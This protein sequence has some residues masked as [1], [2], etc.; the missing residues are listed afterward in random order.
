P[1][2]IF[3][4]L[5]YSLQRRIMICSWQI[6]QELSLLGHVFSLALYRCAGLPT[7]DSNSA[8]L[9]PRYPRYYSNQS[10]HLCQSPTMSEPHTDDANATIAALTKRLHDL[11]TST[12]SRMNVLE[13]VVNAQQVQIDQLI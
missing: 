9:L 8:V 12:T 3:T 4:I 2:A 10:H 7:S 1:S 5:L 11:E 6:L 13:A